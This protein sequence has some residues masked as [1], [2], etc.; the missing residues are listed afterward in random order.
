MDNNQTNAEQTVPVGGDGKVVA[1]VQ[2]LE[3][4]T[5]VEP[6]QPQTQEPVQNETVV[7]QPIQGVP[8]VEQSKEDFIDNTQ[9]L[10]P[11]KKEVKKKEVNYLFMI[12]LFVIIF[13]AI[14]FLFPIL[15]KHI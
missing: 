11:E 2:P 10:T 14:F 3:Q 4:E 8:T 15:L 1:P 9:S 6:I 7:Q 12:I 13:A 5:P